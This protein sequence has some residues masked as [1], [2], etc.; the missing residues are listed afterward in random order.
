M[1]AE[2]IRIVGIAIGTAG[3]IFFGIQLILLF[4]KH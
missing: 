3:S 4:K 1:V 2:I